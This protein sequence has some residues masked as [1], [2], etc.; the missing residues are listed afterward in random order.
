MQLENCNVCPRKCG[1]NRFKETGFCRASGELKV[2]RAFLHVW[3]EPCI[4]GSR[5]SGA[6]FFSNCNL[7][8]VFCQNH[9]ISHGGKG[10][11]LSIK[12]LSE[13]FMELQEK[14]AHNINLVTPTHY[15]P[16]IKEAIIMSKK[17]GLAIPIAYNS[18][19]YESI[20]ALRELEGLIDIF[21]PDLK[22]FNDKYAVKYS[23]AQN[24]FEIA[25]KAVLEMIRQV[26]APVFDG[27]GIM[28]RGV[29]I[30][31]MMLPGLLFDSKKIVDWVAEN[32]P[33]EVYFNIM[34]QYTPM[35]RAQE[36]PE[37]NKRI[38]KKHYEALVD[39]A[40][41]R[42]I[43]NGFFQDVESATEDYVPDF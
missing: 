12:R 11:T 29:M 7:R 20:D 27:E 36:Y 21:I 17:E 30:R 13:I 3:E 39:Y 35:Y 19:G 10:K 8:C 1:I 31:H 4:S 33:S 22:Y 25:S 43:E 23:G 40:I 28:K 16:Q 42:G 14:G 38:N 32:L 26:G 15:I 6:V 9:D 37:I 34:S 24:Y 5:G 41:T 18:N 2:A